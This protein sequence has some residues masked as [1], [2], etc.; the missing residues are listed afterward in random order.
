MSHIAAFRT[1]ISSGKRIGNK[2]CFIF[3]TALEVT[4]SQRMPLAPAFFHTIYSENGKIYKENIP[5][6]H[7]YLRELHEKFCLTG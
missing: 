5:N 4:P 2:S 6:F 1:E 7:L 3:I